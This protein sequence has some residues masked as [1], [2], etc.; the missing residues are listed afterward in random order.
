MCHSHN[1][2]KGTS[3]EQYVLRQTTTHAPRMLVNAATAVANPVPKCP[4]LRANLPECCR[5]IKESS[6]P[7]PNIAGMTARATTSRGLTVVMSHPALRRTLLRIRRSA[8]FSITCT[9]DQQH[10]RTHLRQHRSTHRAYSTSLWMPA[11]LS[12]CPMPLGCLLLEPG[13]ALD[14]RLLV[15]TCG[16]VQRHT[17]RTQAQGQNAGTCD[18]GTCAVGACTA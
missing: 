7:C 9:Q 2:C 3:R 13:A 18:K 1:K 6:S 16:A 5:E 4:A 15:S 11:F 10:T 12:A 14:K 8:S 17:Q